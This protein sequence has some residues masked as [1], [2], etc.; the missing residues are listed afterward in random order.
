MK[1][2]AMKAGQVLSVADLEAVPPEYR[3]EV[4]ATLAS[5]RTRRPLSAS[6]R[7]AASSSVTWASR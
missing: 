2:A 3:E 6:P 5:L 4:R 1:G 7:C